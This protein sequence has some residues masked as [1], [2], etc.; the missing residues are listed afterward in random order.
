VQAI[1]GYEGVQVQF[2]S[3]SELGAG[4]LSASHTAALPQGKES[5]RYRSSR[6]L[7][8]FQRRCTYLEVE[9]GSLAV[10]PIAC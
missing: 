5:P 7:G 3:V 8:G 2:H 9:H 1:Q 6:R 10:Q 4:E